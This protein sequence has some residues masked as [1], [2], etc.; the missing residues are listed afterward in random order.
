MRKDC[1]NFLA[2]S[3]R[4]NAQVPVNFPRQERNQAHNMARFAEGA[5]NNH[6]LLSLLVS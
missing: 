2:S 4:L 3:A 6:R 1:S 5:E